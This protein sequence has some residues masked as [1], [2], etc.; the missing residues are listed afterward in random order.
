MAP[1]PE[2]D[3][4]EL[5]RAMRIAALAKL[6]KPIAELLSAGVPPHFVADALVDDALG[7]CMVGARDPNDPVAEQIEKA[8]IALIALVAKRMKI[9]ME[10]VPKSPAAVLLRTPR[11]ETL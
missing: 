10:T 4:P 2:N 5:E 8:G 7:V 11:P 3:S 6:T 9:L 1:N